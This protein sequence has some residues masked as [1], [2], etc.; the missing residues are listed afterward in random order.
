MIEQA[1]ELSGRDIRDLLR[2]VGGLLFAVGALALWA[3]KSTHHEW[4]GFARLLVVAVPAVLLFVLALDLSTPRSRGK[5]RPAQSVLMVVSILLGPVVL[6]Q[7][8]DWVGASTRH[9]LL[10]A[11]V[12]ALV[13]LLGA[14]AA[15]RT[16]VSYAALLAGL[17]AIVAWLLVWDK[18]LG[19]PSPNT[20][21]WLLVI[22]A[23][24]LFS[25]AFRL[26]RADS[27]GAAEVATAGGVSAVAAGL[28]GVV[29]GAFV[30]TFEAVT[31]TVVSSGGG[32]HSSASHAVSSHISTSGFQ[33]FF[34][35]LYLLVVSLALV[36]IG[37]RA[38]FRGL[39]YVGGVGLFAF[40]VSV[41]VQVTR[42]EVGR[43]PTASVAGW[44]LALLLL[45]AAALA[46]SA[47]SLRDEQAPPLT[48][49]PT[50]H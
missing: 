43:T 14:Y 2:S 47:Y 39:G 42:I 8:L 26:H 17:S 25:A 20:Y 5:T 1:M 24:L 49:P 34:W 46:A 38:R 11:A 45:G 33:H 23:A 27:V 37:S 12:F 22:A 7:F 32:L 9:V 50:G 18:I 29:V 36:W 10:D 15:R 40:L 4:G 28:F 6:F 30:G 44:P 48:P 21:R 19:H 13:A 16:R 31:S 3:R 35:D 41:V